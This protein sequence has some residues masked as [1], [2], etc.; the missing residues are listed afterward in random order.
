MEEKSYGL[1]LT[2][3]KISSVLLRF[4]WPFVA[5][6]LVMALHGVISMVV[7]GQFTG[8]EV[9][10]GV[11]TGTQMMFPLFPFYVGIGTGGT[12]LIG[13]SI[14]EKNDDAGRRAVGSFTVISIGLVLFLTLF[15][16]ILR[17]PLLAALKTPAEALPS[18]RRY[19]MFCTIGVPFNAAYSMICAVAR[20]MGNS[21]APSV[22]AGISCVV[23]ITLSLL[24]VGGAG[25]AEA[26]VG[27]A[28]SAAQFSGFV[29][30]AI[31]IY[32]K[33][34]PFSFTKKDIKA[35]KKSVRFLLVVGCPLILQDLLISISFMINT[36]R[37]NIIGVE[38]SASVGVVQRL[39]NIA[40]V[41]PNSFGSAI[42]AMTA[43]NI[44][45]GKR[46]RASAAMRLGVMYAAIVNAVVVIC[47]L[48]WPEGITS[49][50]SKDRDIIV[51]AANYLRSF[52][53]DAFIVAFV[54]C[55]NAYLSGCGKSNVS[56]WHSL[57]TAFLVRVP[58]SIY[59]TSLPDL[60]LN[61]RLFYLGGISPLASFVSVVVMLIYIRWY[62]KRYMTALPAA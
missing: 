9:I 23:N 32:R 48:I 13:R 45:A 49:A 42:S 38:A 34:L 35:D 1:D 31:W 25:L 21:K 61:T 17:D 51:G 37:V 29:Y 7:V 4:A 54:F 60:A 58:L 22:A 16:L 39:F 59:V 12:V 24:L 8:R 50:F 15:M 27:I 36:N 46:E 55:M 26:G 56:M 19:V 14:G 6:N 62:N 57:A 43:Q 41:V 20:G 44:G 10:S 30:I 5:A 28:T 2:Q 53:L 33:R 52:S 40:G 11:S 47:C 18:A 3:G